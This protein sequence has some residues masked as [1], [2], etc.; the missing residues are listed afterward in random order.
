MLTTDQQGAI[1]ETAIAHEAVRL[2]IE[3]Y[4]PVAEGGR[5][6]LVFAFEDASLARVQCKWAPM[7]DGVIV[8]RSYSCR[9]TADGIRRR[10]Y[11]LDEIDALAAYCP[12]S[13]RCYHVP[14]AKI[15]GRFGFQLRLAPTR[16]NQADG[17]NWAV[18]YEL[19][20]IAQLG[21]RHTGSVEVAGSSPASSIVRRPP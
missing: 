12:D 9:R 3:V 17:V 8:I 4:R 18:E 20:A 21:E 7:Q 10:V 5:F 1:A 19:G 16:N 11:R 14:A 6:D 13:R 15:A 2:G